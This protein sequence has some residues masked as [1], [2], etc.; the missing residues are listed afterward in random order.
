MK[1]KK[2]NLQSG[3]V[4]R[5]AYAGQNFFKGENSF[6]SIVDKSF[7]RASNLLEAVDSQRGVFPVV[8]GPEGGVIF[9][10]SCGHGMESDCVFKGSNFK[11]QIVKQTSA[12]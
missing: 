8:M 2:G 9:H 4:G 6:E 10:E 7:K 12:K 5:A 1:D 3:R 11:D